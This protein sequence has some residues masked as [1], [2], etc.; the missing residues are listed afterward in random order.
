MKV[1]ESP[2]CQSREERMGVLKSVLESR[3]ERV[4]ND[5]IAICENR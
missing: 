3:G 1:D 5:E 2:V 4:R